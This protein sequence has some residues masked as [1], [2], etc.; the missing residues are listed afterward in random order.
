MKHGLA[1]HMP[2]TDGHTTS[3]LHRHCRLSVPRAS[4]GK[5]PT[6]EASGRPHNLTFVRVESDTREE[7]LQPVNL[8]MHERALIFP[9]KNGSMLGDVGPDTAV[10]SC[11]AR[12]HE[13][14]SFVLRPENS[15]VRPRHWV[16]GMMG[17][18]TRATGHKLMI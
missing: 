15:S 16:A 5:N 4:Q 7:K 18:H 17:T 13:L 9:N 1:S 6:L 11:F 10:I 14:T 8:L 2:E 3:H 12:L